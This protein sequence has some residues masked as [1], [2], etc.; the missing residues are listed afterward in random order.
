MPQNDKC[1]VLLPNV[2]YYTILQYK[3]QWVEQS[4]MIYSCSVIAHIKYRLSE[5]LL[6]HK[7]NTVTWC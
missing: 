6:L 2:T 4:G 7:N 5:V 1:G 3:L